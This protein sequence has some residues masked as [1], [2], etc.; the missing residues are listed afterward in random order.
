MAEAGKEGKEEV[1]RDG[2]SKVIKGSGDAAIQA[3]DMATMVM[4]AGLNSAEELTIKASDILLNTA[5]RAVDAGNVIASDVR[6]VTKNM[7]KE[8]LQAA[9]EIGGEVK[10]VASDAIGKGAAAEKPKKEAKTE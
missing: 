2:V 8:T 10:E 3:V 4:K 5:R 1:I 6:E 7:V 9:S